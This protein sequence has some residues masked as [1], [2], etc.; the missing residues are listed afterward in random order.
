MKVEAKIEAKIEALELS[1][2]LEWAGQILLSMR[3]DSPFPKEPRGS[4]P[5]Y[6]KDVEEELKT[7]ANDKPRLSL[8]SSHQISLMDK[9]Y[10]LVSLEKDFYFRRL[11]HSRSLVAPLT[12]RHIVSW[13]KLAQR[14]SSDRRKVSRDHAKALEVL[15]RKISSDKA[16]AIRR[17]FHLLSL[18]P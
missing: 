14:L 4:W 10:E 17:I 8:P 16:Y 11:L 5:D 6:L 7:F 13:T 12:G 3:I 9:I 1:S 2:W 18:S 15:A